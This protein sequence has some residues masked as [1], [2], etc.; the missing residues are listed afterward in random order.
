ML[1]GGGPL[2][3]FLFLDLA[4]LDQV[5]QANGYGPLPRRI[6][7]MGGGGFGGEVTGLRFGGL[8]YGGEVTSFK[9]QKIATLSLGFGGF[10]IARGILAREKFSLS[11]G[12]VIGGGGAELHLLHRRSDT[13]VDAVENPPNTYLSREFFAV[14]TH[15]GAEFVLLDWIMLKVQIGYLWTFGED[16]LQAGVPLAGPPKALGG[17]LVQVMLAFGGRGPLEEEPLPSE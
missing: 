11:V 5:L 9:D 15:I 12:V 7:L 16:W 4:E 6:F 8:G 14:Q 1:G 17:P 10:W 3:G 13:F 2:P